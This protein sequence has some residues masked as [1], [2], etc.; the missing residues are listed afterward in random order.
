VSDGV[1]VRVGVLDA[2]AVVDRVGEALGVGLASGVLVWVGV[3][4]GV[5]VSVAVGVG[6]STTTTKPATLRSARSAPLT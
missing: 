6:W 1:G 5:K 2:V 4:D 3:F